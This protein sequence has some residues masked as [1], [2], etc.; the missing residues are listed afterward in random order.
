MPKISQEKD[1]TDQAEAEKEI[2][3]LQNRLLDKNRVF[4]VE[5]IELSKAA[6]QRSAELEKT[7]PENDNLKNTINE[8]RRQVQE[9]E[10]GK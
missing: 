8:L 6:S 1:E 2:W 3:R 10:G 7:K 9:L 5:L 4:E